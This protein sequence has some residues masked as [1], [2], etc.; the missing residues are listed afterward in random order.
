LY[1]AAV[2]AH[3]PAGL[4]E[5]LEAPSELLEAVEFATL[6]SI[7]RCNDRQLG[8]ISEDDS[9]VTTRRVRSDL[10]PSHPSRR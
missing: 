1:D 7:D 8:E 5:L 4:S 9:Y 10:L 6:G 3:L 2:R